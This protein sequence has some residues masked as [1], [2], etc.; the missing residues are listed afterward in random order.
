VHTATKSLL[1]SS[2]AANN[3]YVLFVHGW[4]M[5][6]NERVVFAETSLKRLYWAGYRG[7]FGYFSWPT[8]YFYKPAWELQIIQGVKALA[9]PQNYDRSEAIARRSGVVLADLVNSLTV[10]NDIY[11]FAHSMGNVVVSEALRQS[12]VNNGVLERYIASQAAEAAHAYNPVAPYRDSTN[13]SLLSVY[14]LGWLEL[15]SSSSCV[16]EYRKYDDLT[17]KANLLDTYTVSNPPPELKLEYSICEIPDKYSYYSNTIHALDESKLSGSDHPDYYYKGIRE[18][19]GS[20]INF[21]SNI[22]FALAGWDL[23][24]ATKPDSGLLGNPEWTYKGVASYDVNTEN[25]FWEVEDQFLFNEAELD[26]NQSN[27]VP[28]QPE[29]MAHIIPARSLSLGR[30][31][32]INTFGNGGEFNDPGVNLKD[33]FGYTV[34]A[35]D[36]SAQF[37]STYQARSAYWVR[38]IKEFGID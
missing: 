13:S 4:R 28:G 9:N 22:D 26:I 8:D 12:S 5:Q 20:I 32:N 25:E 38:L 36:H 21:Y 17:T 15:N 11:T 19:A 14:P 16:M 31:Q 1:S 2:S 18:K 7:K 27:D 23:N 35:Y 3:D 37:L 6:Y 24:A 34:S 33:E 29:I 10:S 30:Q